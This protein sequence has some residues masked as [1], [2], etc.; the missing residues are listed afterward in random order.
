MAEYPPDQEEPQGSAGSV[1]FTP[2]AYDELRSRV[3]HY[4]RELVSEA[5]RIARRRHPDDAVS[6]SE[7]E[8]ACDNLRVGVR[9]RNRTLQIIGTLGGVLLGAATGNVLQIAGSQLISA[10]SILLTF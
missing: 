5:A 3:D 9:P 10:E 2:G 4:A 6:I 7:I 1:P 8:R